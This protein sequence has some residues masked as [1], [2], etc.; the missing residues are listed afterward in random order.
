MHETP[1]SLDDM[2]TATSSAPE[3]TA[4]H[5]FVPG[6][7]IGPFRIEALIGQ[8]GMGEVYRAVREEWRPTS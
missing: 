3:R 7:Q 2:P 8:G 5:D 1:P 6:T 4:T